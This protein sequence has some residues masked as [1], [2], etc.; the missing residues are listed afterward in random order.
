MSRVRCSQHWCVTC[1]DKCMTHKEPLHNP[2]ARSR[3]LQPVATRNTT[4]FKSY[5]VSALT[6]SKSA[7]SSARSPRRS[8][9]W[10]GSLLTA[11]AADVTDIIE[12]KKSAMPA[13][14]SEP[15]GGMTVPAG[16]RRGGHVRRH[17]NTHGHQACRPLAAGLL[18]TAV[19]SLHKAAQGC[20]RPELTCKV[21]P[22]TVLAGP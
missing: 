20:T 11:C 21:L 1:C 18:L 17:D 9:M 6:A 2:A 3:P 10:L 5:A 8:S 15:V 14:A 22:A 12:T 19:A 13:E 7:P 16:S 4:A